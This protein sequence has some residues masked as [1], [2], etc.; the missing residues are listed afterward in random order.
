MKIGRHRPAAS[1]GVGVNHGRYLH[2]KKESAGLS[3]DASHEFPQRA[4]KRDSSLV[5]LSARFLSTTH[6]PFVSGRCLS[7]IP[8]FVIS[9]ITLQHAISISLMN[10]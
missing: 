7:Q 3:S 8:A 2:N 5:Q 1:V 9:V 4:A 6:M 10:P